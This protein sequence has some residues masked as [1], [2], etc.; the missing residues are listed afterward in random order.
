MI[1]SW[2]LVSDTMSWVGDVGGMFG[3]NEIDEVSTGDLYHERI[4]PD[5]LKIRLKGLSKHF[6]SR[7]AFD[8]EY[9]VRTEKGG[10]CWIHD[11]GAADF[12]ETGQP[13]RL[14]GVLRVVTGRK[15]HEILLEQRANYDELTGLYNKSR[16]REAVDHALAYAD[17]YDFSGGFLAVGIDKMSMMNDAYGR[18]TADAVIVGV[19]QRLEE[20][21]RAT[22]VIGRL[23]GDT[24]GIVLGNSDELGIAAAAEKILNVFRQNAVQTP[25]GPVHITVSIG[26]AGFP[27]LIQTP[28]DLIASAEGA[29]RDAKR[30]GRNC[31]AFYEMSEEQRLRQREYMV[32]GEQVIKALQEERV[33]FAYQPVVDS[34]TKEVAYFETLIR[35]IDERGEIVAAGAFVPIAERLGLMRQLDRRTLEMVVA[36]LT[37]NPDVT[38][39]LNISSLTASDRSWLRA[40]VGLVKG[41]PDIANRLIIEITETAALHDFE[42]S[43]RFVAAVR[44]LG[45]KVALDD[46]GSGYTSFRHL[47][48]LTVDVVKIDG[49]FVMNVADNPDNLLFIRTLLNLA[50]G[51][52][53]KTVAE[54]VQSPKDAKLLQ[55]EGVN[56]M[57]GYYYGRPQLGRPGD[58][59]PVLVA[60]NENRQQAE[61]TRVRAAGSAAVAD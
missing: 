41:K 23:G 45:C 57:Q 36:D 35:M 38:L 10:F 37:S 55:E 5:D 31:F 3:F 8:C 54:C 9:R 26:G 1:Y 58:S 28:H 48:S 59:K 17:R 27:G 14:N 40:L 33:V 42:D 29:M 20:C 6:S 21:M 34:Q 13:I 11:R 49:S 32:V 25:V 56:F 2:D 7:D 46:F 51:F 50:E 22:D 15:Q 43:A 30:L 4:N 12:S 53:M 18:E 52:G 60:E 16:L 47:K 44:D 39:A 24:F 61:T 19:A